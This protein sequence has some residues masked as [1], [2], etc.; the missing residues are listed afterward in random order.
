MGRGSPLSFPRFPQ[1][2]WEMESLTQVA[3]G[4]LSRARKR[5]R[6]SIRGP[7]HDEVAP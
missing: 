6:I 2:V 4:V 1:R 3:G 7:A 5:L